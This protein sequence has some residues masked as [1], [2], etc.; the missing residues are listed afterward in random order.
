MTIRNVKSEPF[1]AFNFSLKTEDEYG[2]LDLKLMSI[3][4]KKG[5]LV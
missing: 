2:I 1:I 3:R 4:G 5:P